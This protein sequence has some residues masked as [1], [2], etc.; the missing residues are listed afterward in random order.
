MGIR[1][2]HDRSI[3]QPNLACCQNP[4]CRER[5]DQVFTFPV[6]HDHFACPK[7]GADQ[8]PM[9]CLLVMIH[10]LIPRKDGPILGSF[11]RR[12]QIACDNNRA[13][14]ATATNMEAVTVDP[15]VVNCPGCL[16]ELEKQRVRQQTGFVTILKLNSNENGDTT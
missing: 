6:E 15:S 9:V 3:K 16:A 13:Y 2:P 7:C 5:S 11:G 12:Y 8:E 10:G 1:I 4:A 14:L